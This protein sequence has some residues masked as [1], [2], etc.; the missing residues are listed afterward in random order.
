MHCQGVCWE[1]MLEFSLHLT[2]TRAGRGRDAGRA[3]AGLLPEEEEHHESQV[4][5]REWLLCSWEGK[6]SLLLSCLCCPWLLGF[7]QQQQQVF[8]QGT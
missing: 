4:K 2:N 7:F 6:G 5:P 8:M 1:K 3:P